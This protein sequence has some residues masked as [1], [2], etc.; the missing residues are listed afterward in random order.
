MKV[1]LQLTVAMVFLAGS[2]PALAQEPSEAVTVFAP[3]VVKKVETQRGIGKRPTITTISVSRN[4]SYHDLD[5]TAD[6]G[7]TALAGRVRQAA[8]DVCRELA[9]R[10]PATIYVPVA[11]EDKN[12]AKNV[13]A[14]AM[15]QV[16]AVVEASRVGM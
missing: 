5:L 11:G 4:V 7:E 16:H 2:V 14:E 3:Y 15:M 8:Q 9:R 12:C 10:F 13:E 1:Y 6:A